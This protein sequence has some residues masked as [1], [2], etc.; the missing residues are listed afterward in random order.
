M[1]KNKIL[2]VTP[3]L[4]GGVGRVILNYLAKAKS[5]HVFE[6]KVLCLDYAKN[7]AVRLAS[8]IGLTLLDNM[9][10]KKP[11]L[12]ELLTQADIILIHWWNHPLLYDFLVRTQLPP[13]RLVMWS[14]IS[15]FHPPY[16]FTEKIFQ[17]PDIFV[18]TTPASLETKEVKN[19]SD[20]QKN[21]LRVVWSTGGIEH[22]K[23]VKPKAHKG[24]NVGYIGTVDYAK[25][26]P[27]FLNICRQINI[28][29]VKFI[30]CGGPSEK[31]IHLEAEKLGIA[32]KFVF[33]GQI[34]DINEYLSKFDV[35]GYPLAPYHYGTCDQSLQE[36]MAAGVV[37]VVFS[38]RM[39]RLMV[40]DGVTGIVAKNKN[41]YIKNIEKLY[42]DKVLRESL[43]KNAKKY[44]F[45]FFSMDKMMQEW[46]TIF[47]EILYAPK[48]PKNWNIAK[49]S[50]K[51]KAF[52]VFLESLGDY[53]KDFIYYCKA[54]SDAEKKIAIQK[55]KKLA[56]FPYW[57]AK[58]RGTVHHYKAFFPADDCLFALNQLM[59]KNE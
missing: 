7:N 5:D 8:D 23:D 33:T 30:V 57:Q 24:F 52:D 32:K 15:G 59:N 20:K 14:H 10:N 37:P 19:L 36:S 18:F 53:G 22:V 12:L 4:G 21:I 44:A 34:L 27:N 28:P 26:H 2:H 17:Y 51:I 45:E 29:N 11:K 46:K 35:F 50:N 55:I 47:K 25:L 9:A 38:N 16:V 39:E 31:K 43:S 48:S 6:H 49:K 13:C 41:D 1:L 3:H 56:K 40:Q 54:K 58:T 42:N